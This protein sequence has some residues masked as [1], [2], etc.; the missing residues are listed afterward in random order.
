MKSFVRFGVWLGAC[1]VAW[2]VGVGM[3]HE[4]KRMARRGY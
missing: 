1:L 3:L 4:A 2:F